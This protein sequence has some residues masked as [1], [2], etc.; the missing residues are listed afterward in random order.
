MDTKFE[1]VIRK[2][3]GAFYIKDGTVATDINGLHFVAEG[4]N[5]VS[6]GRK[7][8]FLTY[9]VSSKDGQ[10]DEEF[11]GL[12][13]YDGAKFYVNG[14]EVVTDMNGLYLVKAAQMMR[15]PQTI[16]FISSLMD[17]FRANTKGLLYMTMNGSIWK[18]VFRY[19]Y[20]WNRGA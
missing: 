14:G 5:V 3:E 6:I 13:E 16:N 7:K 20:K 11:E 2:Y 1:G 12:T 8:Y 4:Y 10:V 15:R 17:R 19:Q 18:I 9:F